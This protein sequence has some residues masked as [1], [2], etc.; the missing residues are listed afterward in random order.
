[1]RYKYFSAFPRL[2]S[3]LLDLIVWMSPISGENVIEVQ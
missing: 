1:M 2:V 3:P